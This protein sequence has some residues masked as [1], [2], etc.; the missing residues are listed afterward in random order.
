MNWLISICKPEGAYAQKEERRTSGLQSG[1][2]VTSARK[3]VILQRIVPGAGTPEDQ[4]GGIQR[5]SDL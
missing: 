1:G 5:T 2:D 3:W 4:R